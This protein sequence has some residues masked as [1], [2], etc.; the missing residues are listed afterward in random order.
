[1]NICDKCYIW[2]D[3]YML[4]ENIDVFIISYNRFTY[5]K[6]IVDWLENLGFKNIHIVDN[7]STYP[8]LLEYLNKSKH[9]VVRLSH[10]YGHLVIW[11]SNKFD[12]IVKNKYYIVTD[13]DVLP[14]NECP[15]DIVEYFISILD[16]YKNITKVGFSLNIDDIP[17]HYIYKKNVLLWEKKFWEKKIKNNLYDAPIDTT[18]ALYR[19]NIYP[20]NKKWWKSIRTGYP[21]SARHLPWY[22]NISEINKEEAYYQESL[23]KDSSCW[24]VTDF[25][26]LKKNNEE[27]RIE[28]SNIIN[29]NFNLVYKLIYKFIFVLFINN[30]KNLLIK[31]ELLQMQNFKLTGFLNH[32]NKSKI[33]NF[34]KKSN[35]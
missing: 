1:M 5:L 2:Y 7:N 18:F 6:S 19:P 8:P 35:Y 30:N 33:S 32:L 17:D 27:L 21:Y 29:K 26:L 24:S 12:L 20:G 23:K 15:N 34:F 22:S 13:C 4:N 11:N 25:N 10:N 16:K 3:I 31:P 9:D 28:V 14:M